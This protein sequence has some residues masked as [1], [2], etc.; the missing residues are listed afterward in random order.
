MDV[1]EVDFTGLPV[2]FTLYGCGTVE[3]VPGVY[4]NAVEEMCTALRDP[5]ND[6]SIPYAPWNETCILNS[7][8]SP[9]R[10]VAPGSIG[11]DR[12]DDY[13]AA[14]VDAV[15]EYYTINTL[16]L[17]G[18]Y[19]TP[20]ANCTVVQ[21]VLNCTGFNRGFTRPTATDIFGCST[22]P[23]EGLTTDN[24]DVLV[25]LPIVCAAFNRGTFLLSV[26]IYTH[27]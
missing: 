13:W 8:G 20:L 14:Y 2:G 23:F 21:D 6:P 25:G 15:W 18:D 22:G 16:Q 7:T 17:L 11:N 26:C 1:T 3:Q 10:V 24:Y 19:A 12:F 9:I 4:S 5:P 27:Y